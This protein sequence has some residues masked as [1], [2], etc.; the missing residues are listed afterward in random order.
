MRIFPEFCNT[1]V[2]PSVK[3]DSRYAFYLYAYAKDNKSVYPD[4]NVNYGLFCFYPYDTPHH[5]DS[6]QH[7]ERAWIGRQTIAAWLRMTYDAERDT[8]AA[9]R[10]RSSSTTQH[11]RTPDTQYTDNRAL[12]TEGNISG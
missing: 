3:P 6:I 4:V 11:V 1:F 10:F 12:L 7:P 9:S 2:G 8:Y 5:Q